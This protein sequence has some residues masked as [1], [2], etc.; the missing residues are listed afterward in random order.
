MCYIVVLCRHVP[1]PHFIVKYVSGGIC[2]HFDMDALIG[3]SFEATILT[4]W[5]INAIP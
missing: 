2:W 1:S 5:P 4:T 3:N